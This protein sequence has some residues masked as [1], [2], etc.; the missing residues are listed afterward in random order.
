MDRLKFKSY[1]GE[2]PNLCSGTLKMILDGKVIIFP[3]YCLRSGGCVS[4][5]E[6]GEEVTEGDWGIEE[7]PK[8]FPKKLKERAE[9]LVNENVSKGCCGGCV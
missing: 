3:E 9:E 1:D 6:D 8:G 7:Y 4:F 2:Y 5:N